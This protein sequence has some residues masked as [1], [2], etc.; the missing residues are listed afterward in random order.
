M[1]TQRFKQ[2]HVLQKAHHTRLCPTRC[3]H[4]L[5]KRR[6]LTSKAS[7]NDSPDLIESLV[8]KLFGRQALEDS[9]PFGMKRMSA[10]DYPEMYPATTDQ[11][12]DPLAGD[13]KEVAT[14]RP[15]LARTQLERVPLRLA[16]DAGRDGW[17]AAAFHERVNTFGA[18]L[19]VLQTAGGAVVG[20]YNPRGWIGLGEDRD[21]IAAFLFTWPDGNTAA[22]P[23][24][25]P[26]VGGPSM[27]VID[28]PSNGVKFGPDG[29]RCLVP[30]KERVAVS[31]LGTYY[32][33]LPDGGRSLFAPGE[34]ARGA[35]VVNVQCWVA[36]GAGEA[37]KLD[38][39][40]WSTERSGG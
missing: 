30:G 10:E 20:G 26:K 33:R 3:P 23:I 8:G 35:E 6:L 7:G 2:G 14:L 38:G 39:I 29:L 40:V 12:A 16:Y 1:R 24:K 32:A 28:N 37:W 36:E 34:D 25:L 11:W 21:A 19:V 17:S 18:G 5:Q 31:R 22:R 27:A 15:L 13:S 4:T 9:S